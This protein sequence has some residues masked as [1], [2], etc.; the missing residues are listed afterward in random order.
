MIVSDFHCKSSIAME[1]IESVLSVCVCVCLFCCT[2]TAEP[3]L[4]VCWFIGAKGLLG[5]GIVQCGALEV[6]QGWGVFIEE[7]FGG[8]DHTVGYVCVIPPRVG[9]L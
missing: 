5:Q 6:L 2:L 4:Y 7:C 9:H 8:S 1:V 3:C